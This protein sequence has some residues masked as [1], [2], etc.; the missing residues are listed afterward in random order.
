MSDYISLLTY[1]HVCAKQT[2]NYVDHAI[3][4]ALWRWCLRRHPNKGKQWV[5]TKYFK[6]TVFRSWIFSAK[7][8]HEGKEPTTVR[9]AEASKIP[10]IRHVK[11]RAEATP[12]DPSHHEYLG[13]RLRKR[14]RERRTPIR[15]KWYSLWGETLKLKDDKLGHM[16]VA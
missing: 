3:F 10:I 12:Y 6:Q 7:V 9:L 11:I 14:L 15:P 16:K 13:E 8:K 2:F 1:Q 5:K 4:Q